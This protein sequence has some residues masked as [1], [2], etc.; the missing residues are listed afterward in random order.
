MWGKT[1][2]LKV[3]LTNEVQFFLFVHF[4]FSFPVDCIVI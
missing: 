1:R 4:V 3:P 2:P